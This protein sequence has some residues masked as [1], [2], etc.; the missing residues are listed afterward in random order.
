MNAK[1]TARRGTGQACDREL[2]AWGGSD[3]GIRCAGSA[4]PRSGSAAD[5]AYQLR[6]PM[7]RC[8]S[9]RLRLPSRTTKPSISA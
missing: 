4:L 7:P 9:H 3:G 1:A 8:S 2:Y 5:D 6:S